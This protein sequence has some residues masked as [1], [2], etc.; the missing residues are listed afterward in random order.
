MSGRTLVSAILLLVLGNLLAIASDVVVK[1]LGSQVPV[2]QFVFMRS[3]ASLILMAPFLRKIDRRHLF[4]GFRVHL[5]R[6][7]LALFGIGCMVIALHAL[8]LAT[9]NALFYA[10]PLLVLVISVGFFRERLTWQSLLAVVSGFAGILVILRPL[11]VDWRCLSAFGVAI[12]LALSAVLVRK[13]PKKQSSIHTLVVTYILVLPGSLILALLEGG[14]WHWKLM[15]QAGASS[16]FILGYNMTVLR[17]Y[18][19]VDANQVTS[20]EYTGLIWA[21]LAGWLVFGEMPDLW[22]FLGTAMIVLPLILVG[23]GSRHN[24]RRAQSSR[25][26]WDSREWS[27]PDAS[28]H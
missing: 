24:R 15:L 22:F 13:L 10:A 1:G 25:S 7:H 17:A 21:V 4:E 5:L 8:P 20:A 2:F 19:H 11:V 14:P 16:F 18:R 6:A 26:Q 12:T 28:E 23:V 9:A 27:S 3:L